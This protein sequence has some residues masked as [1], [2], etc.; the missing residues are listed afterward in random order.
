M[1]LDNANLLYWYNLHHYVELI[2]AVLDVYP[3]FHWTNQ[4]IYGLIPRELLP[5][6]ITQC[7]IMQCNV[8]ICSFLKKIIKIFRRRR[9][10]Y[11]VLSSTARLS[12]IT[13]TPLHNDAR[14]HDRVNC[15]V[16]TFCYPRQHINTIQYILKCVLLAFLIDWKIHLLN[17]L[18]N[19]FGKNI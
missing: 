6:P 10:G 9:I 14:L 5:M 19:N 11:K 16:H 3:V 7:C 8:A 13:W 2:F 15:H 4:F 18:L 12:M 1:Y 17:T